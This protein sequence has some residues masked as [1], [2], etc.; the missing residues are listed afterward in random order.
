MYI[1][2]VDSGQFGTSV[3]WFVRIGSERFS[4]GRVSSVRVGSSLVSLDRVGSS[5]RIGGGG[6]IDS[7]LHVALPALVLLS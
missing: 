1:H 6:G 5:V 7:C 3:G 2:S 4:S